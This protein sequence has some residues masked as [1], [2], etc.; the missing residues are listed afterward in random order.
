[1]GTPVEEIYRKFLGMIEDE[2]WLLVDEDVIED[3]MLNYLENA[4]VEFHQCKKDLTIDFN[5]MCFVEEL[6][7]NEILIL[8]WGMV[9]HYLQPKIKR[10]ENLRQFISDKDF[11]KLSNANMLMRLMG[12]EDKARKQLEV[13][14]NKY[15]FKECTGWN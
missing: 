9:I 15:R 14:Q 10:E 5:N 12:L 6:N 1:M 11:S 2:E 4:T 8:A 13:Y 7:M 3:L